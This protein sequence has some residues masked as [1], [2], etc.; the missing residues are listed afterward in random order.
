MKTLLLSILA[1]TSY[2]SE[3]YQGF[4]G[5]WLKVNATAYSP[6]DGIDSNYRST[7]G[8]KWLWITA[9]G[10][11][12]VRWIPYGIAVPLKSGTRKPH[13]PFGTKVIIPTG[14]GYVDNS[15]P[16]RVFTIDDV[17]NGRQYYKHDSKGQLH[18]DLRFKTHK[19]AIEW[20]GPKGNRDITV[21]VVTSEA[22]RQREIIHYEDLPLFY[23]IE[24]VK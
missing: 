22:P 8:P 10:R 21:F 11:T 4:T 9:D 7:K 18:I 20:A 6:H 12:D 1:L 16:N 23:P 17:G 3:T 15:V 5:Y 24:P 14:Y 13:F 2:A 19:S